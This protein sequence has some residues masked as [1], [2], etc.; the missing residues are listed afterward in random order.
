MNHAIDLRE[1]DRLHD[2]AHRL[3]PQLRDE[4]I[5]DFWRGAND[6]L[7]HGLSRAQRAATRLAHRLQHHDASRSMTSA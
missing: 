2:Q 6:L 5:D 1:L 7:Q 3:A 4:A